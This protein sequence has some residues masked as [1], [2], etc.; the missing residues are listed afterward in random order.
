M[1]I[2]AH[3]EEIVGVLYD[4]KTATLVGWIYEDEFESDQTGVKQ[5]LMRNVNG[6]CFLLQWCGALTRRTGARIN[7]MTS[8]DA[9][10]WCETHGVDKQTMEHFFVSSK[11]VSGNS[12]PG[13]CALLTSRWRS[14]SPNDAAS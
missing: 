1:Q 10:H 12:V 13:V 11:P 4:T 2:P 3:Q 6:R 5:F 9:Q 8:E 14:A 7:P